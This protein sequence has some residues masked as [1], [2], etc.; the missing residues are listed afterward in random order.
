MRL[1]TETQS[2]DNILAFKARSYS[3]ALE[4]TAKSL[5]QTG[6]QGCV[7]LR[8]D[9]Q[10][11]SSACPT[12]LFSLVERGVSMGNSD[13]SALNPVFGA[14]YVN[15]YNLGARIEKSGVKCFPDCDLMRSLMNPDVGDVLKHFSSCF[16]TMRFVTGSEGRLHTDSGIVEKDWLKTAFARGLFGRKSIRIIEYDGNVP[17]TMVYDPKDI[18]QKE[19]KNWL[20]GDRQSNFPDFEREPEPWALRS[21]DALFLT[22]GSWSREKLLIHSEPKFKASEMKDARIIRIYDCSPR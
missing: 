15:W 6:V 14:S 21:S 22:N 2:P 7:W 12:E 5:N 3:E 19:Y 16:M 9:F 10:Q 13:L 8:D 20:N 17:G 1:I 18:D 11:V 4:I